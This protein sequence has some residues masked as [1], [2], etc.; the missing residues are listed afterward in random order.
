VI[1]TYVNPWRMGGPPRYA[2]GYGSVLA[3]PVAG[4]VGLLEK[5][6]PTDEAAVKE[7][8]AQEITQI[9]EE[10]SKTVCS[11]CPTP[12]TLALGVIVVGALGV[13]GG[14][15]LAGEAKRKKKGG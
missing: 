5:Y 14:L 7:E 8:I 2:T 15:Y 9:C 4:V 13:A 6:F 12:S 3:L 10:R 11:A 1:V